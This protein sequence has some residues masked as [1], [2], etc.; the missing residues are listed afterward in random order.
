MESAQIIVQTIFMEQT[1]FVILA[2]IAVLNA[3]IQLIA[4]N[5]IMATYISKI[6]AFPLLALQELVRMMIIT[7]ILVKFKIAQ[8]VHQLI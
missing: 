3:A 1:E 8:L 2:L 4:L 5:A 6:I 7:V